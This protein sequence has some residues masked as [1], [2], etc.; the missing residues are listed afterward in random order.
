MWKTVPQARAIQ[1]QQRA[2]LCVAITLVLMTLTSL[3]SLPTFA[4]TGTTLPYNN[5]SPIQLDAGSQEVPEGTMLPLIFRTPLDA[6]VTQP[7]E[8]FV[9][10]LKT[11]FQLAPTSSH[12]T[13]RLILPMGTP[14]RGRVSKVTKPRW[15]S[16]GGMIQLDFDH[17]VLP[18]GELLPVHLK[19][20]ASNADVKAINRPAALQN[21]QT[22]TT[23]PTIHTEYGLYDDPGVGTKIKQ[24]VSEGATQ[25]GDITTAGQQWGESWGGKAGAVATTPFAAVGGALV[26]G[27]TMAKN[28][29][30]ALVMPGDTAMI[31]PGDEIIVDFGHAFVMP[32]E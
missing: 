26:G 25:V 15:F 5:H 19:L 32:A 28:S 29:V 27:A 22:A 30:K 6:R 21:T 14:I 3:A 23:P 31:E 2:T 24:G 11:N 16:K 17:V 7:G 8:P 18:N 10:T 20:S 9:A 12:P 4:Q 1:H 13:P